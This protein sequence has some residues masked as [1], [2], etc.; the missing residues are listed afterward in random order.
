MKK[1]IV[2]MIRKRL[3]LK[4]N[5]IFQF[6]NQI[7][8]GVV[9]YFSKTNLVEIAHGNIRPSDISL[10]MLLGDR[11]NIKKLGDLEE[12]HGHFVV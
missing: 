6:E 4:E 12:T 10:N 9:F 3:G 7:G 5:E 1:L 11:C 8:R 2:F